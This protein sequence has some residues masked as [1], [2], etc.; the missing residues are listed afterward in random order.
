MGES[1]AVEKPE[2]SSKSPHDEMA[3]EVLTIEAK[4]SNRG[5][6]PPIEAKV[7]HLE[8]KVLHLE[9]K[10]LTKEAKPSPK[11]EMRKDNIIRSSIQSQVQFTAV[12]NTEFCTDNS[13]RYCKG[14]RQKRTSFQ[15]SVLRKLC[16]SKWQRFYIFF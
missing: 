10:V 7:L 8:A 12:S 13:D 1:Q 15:L 16:Q 14:T 6:S 11:L 5:E 2:L 9:A 3:A 4:S